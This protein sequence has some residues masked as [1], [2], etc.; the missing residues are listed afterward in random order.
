MTE[1]YI[2]LFYGLSNDSIGYQ[3]STRQSLKISVPHKTQHWGGGRYRGGMEGN[4]VPKWK[5]VSFY[6]KNKKYRWTHRDTFIYL[7]TYLFIHISIHE[8]LC[9]SSCLYCI[10]LFTCLSILSNILF[11]FLF[12]FFSVCLFVYLYICLSV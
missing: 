1:L 10:Y 2:G 7:F 12:F 6:V 3:V 5:H 11:F 8:F 4:N 9:M